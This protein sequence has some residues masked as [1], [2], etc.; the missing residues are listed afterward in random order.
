MNDPTRN[1]PGARKLTE[2]LF[3][4]MLPIAVAL[5]LFFPIKSLAENVPT[6]V[7]SAIL[8]ENWTRV[9]ECLTG[10]E[11]NGASATLRIIKGNACIALN[12]NNESI[13]LFL[14]VTSNV[15]RLEY[16]KWATTFA[17]A[18]ASKAIA[19]YFEGDAFARQTNWDEA[20]KAFDKAID[21]KPDCALAYNARG[22]VYAREGDVS[23]AKENFDKAIRASGGKLAD[24]YN[25]IGY[26][27]I[28]RKDG[29]KG[30]VASFDRALTNAP[31]FALAFHGKGCIEL[32]L[33]MEEQGSK[34]LK[35]GFGYGLSFLNVMLQNELRYS[36]FSAGQSPD[37]MFAKAS[38]P[39]MSLQSK[40]S[41]DDEVNQ[42][43]S[44]FAYANGLRNG[45]MP[46]KDQIA[47][48]VDWFSVN[49]LGNAY[50][51]GGQPAVNEFRALYPDEVAQVSQVEQNLTSVKADQSMNIAN[52]T[53]NI[54]ADSVKT[55]GGNPDLTSDLYAI[56]NNLASKSFSMAADNMMT[57]FQ[58]QQMN[59]Q[60]VMRDLSIQNDPSHFNTEFNP[61][62]VRAK[63]H[64]RSGNWP[65]LPLYGLA[66][67]M[68]N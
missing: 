7:E 26:L 38:N 9:T 11:T 37:E 54:V 21:I 19:Y 50:A 1:W 60:A 58:A 27:W 45:S 49:H 39:G 62:G 30:A 46:F 65:F 3:S 67:G 4:F 59:N 2:V 13:A 41:I 42:A 61:S 64:F 66:Y 14:S 36:A 24:A 6:T 56:A 34:D 22:V 8:A 31:S 16:Q 57:S 29:A 17:E 25:N 18:N 55:A 53:M 15:E 5:V 40:I 63:V 48:M 28:Q 51:S 47:D 52:E 32:I 20:N 35:F 43:G 23:K 44:G 33:G 10:V 12:R 68:T